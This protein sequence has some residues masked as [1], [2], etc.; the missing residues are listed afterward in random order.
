MSQEDSADLD[1][2]DVPGP[3]SSSSSMVV[4]I[5]NVDGVVEE[6]VTDTDGNLV[7]TPEQALSALTEER[8]KD[9]EYIAQLEATNSSLKAN[10]NQLETQIATGM[11]GITRFF[12][13]YF[14]F[15]IILPTIL[16]SS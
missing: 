8:K 12:D 16:E 5:P 4:P 9:L 14:F 7:L 10:V 15:I 3:G 13:G 2:L 1:S 11:T 6:S